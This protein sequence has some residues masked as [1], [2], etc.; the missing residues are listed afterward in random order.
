MF[1]SLCSLIS[2]DLISIP[3]KPVIC[4]ILAYA[5]FGFLVLVNLE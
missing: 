4:F 1:S 2:L 5:S 3:Q